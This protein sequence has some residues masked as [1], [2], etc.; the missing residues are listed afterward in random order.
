[1]NY[2][3]YLLL[4]PEGCI[5]ENEFGFYSRKAEAALSEYTFGR[6][7]E[8]ELQEVKCAWAE[9]CRLYYENRFREGIISESNDGI[10]VSYAQNEKSREKEIIKRWLGAS[11]LMYSGVH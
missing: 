1:M 2:G 8:S 6:S 4:V 9:L 7:K 5:P 3:E 11:G 10:S